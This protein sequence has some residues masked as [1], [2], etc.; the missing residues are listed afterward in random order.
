QWVDRMLPDYDNL[1]AAFEHAMA[2]HDVGLALRLVASLG[3]LI[4]MRI[5]YE[6][7]EWAERA[8][9]V[10][11]PDHPRFA[12][13]AGT[14]ARGFWNRGCLP[15]ARRLANR[16]K[17]RV[18]ATG[19]ARVSYPA[20][21]L[22]DVGLFEG[23]LQGAYAYWVGEAARARSDGDQLRYV[24]TQFAFAIGAGVLGAP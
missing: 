20:D 7:A 17:G 1:R 4:G 11:D 12:A 24:W 18:P 10:A 2:H 21:V 8:I 6:P 13:A 15:H 14:A 3:E 9:A 23:D 5:G 16:A 22:A 19:T